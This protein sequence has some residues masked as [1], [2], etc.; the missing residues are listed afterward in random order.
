MPT[1]TARSP[2]P[3][4]APATRP[5]AGATPSIVPWREVKVS[6]RG[7]WGEER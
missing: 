4:K 2:L 3:P 5:D 6:A 7:G 1:A